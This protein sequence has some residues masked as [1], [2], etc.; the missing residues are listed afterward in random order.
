MGRYNC[1]KCEKVCKSIYH[2]N[3]HKNFVH[4]TGNEEW[5]YCTNCDMLL[6]TTEDFYNR[7]KNIPLST[8]SNKCKKCTIKAVNTDQIPC[9]ICGKQ[10]Y[11]K[12]MR[13]HQTSINCGKKVIIFEIPIK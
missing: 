3:T 5:K 8:F 9:P 10:S 11:V 2:L 7:N 6:K 13:R 1:D 12:N 4:E